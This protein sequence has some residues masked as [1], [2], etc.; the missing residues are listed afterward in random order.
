MDKL[1]TALRTSS[2]Q[3]YEFNQVLFGLCN[4]PANFLGLMDRV[5]TGFNWEM[6][7]FYLDDKIAFSKPWEEHLEH[8]EGVFQH[9]QEAKLKL[10]ASKC[11]LA[12]PEVSYLGHLMT[13]EDLL[14]DPTLLQAI[15][16]IPT[17]QNMK[18]VQSILGLTSYYR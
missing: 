13:R 15:R 4:T 9:L 16:D 11:T 10:G 3:L 6:C 5:L 8:L 18:E 14:S 17:L 2:G 7:L 12:A 1:N